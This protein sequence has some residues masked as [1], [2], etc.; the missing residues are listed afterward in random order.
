[1]TQEVI[2]A[3]ILHVRYTQKDFEPQVTDFK[4]QI[5]SF[6]S[7]PVFQLVFVIALFSIIFTPQTAS[8]NIFDFFTHTA[9]AD[10]TT[11]TPSGNTDN[12]QKM[13]IPEPN[14]GPNTSDNIDP[15]VSDI[16]INN[17]ALTP[18]VGPLGSTLDVADIPEGGGQINIYTVHAGDTIGSIAQM[19]NVSKATIIDA[20]DLTRGQ[21]LQQGT[22]LAIPS[23]SGHIHTVKNGDTVK[24]LAKKYKVDA[25]DIAEYND[26]DIDSELTE[27]TTLIIP[28][29]TYTD[30]STPNTLKN[31]SQKSNSSTKKSNQQSNLS[32]N[33]TNLGPITAH[34]M[35]IDIKVDLGNALLRP[36]DI[37]V[38]YESQGAHG[39]FGSAV[40]LAAPT[41]T[42]IHASAD[43]TVVLA[44][45]SGWNSGYGAYV[46]IMS[47]ID[48][49]VVQTIYAHMSKVI[50]TV[51]EQVNRGDTIG[52][53]GR[54]GNA[55]GPHVHFEVHGAL[56]PLTINSDYT[57]E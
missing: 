7:K 56:N 30:T 24:S 21:S 36:V 17:A 16:T 1:M 39:I 48:G 14:V 4:A 2:H 34:P 46:I 41:G 42:P 40:D 54:T 57:G 51:G 22:I 37:G 33:G 12:S 25:I 43:G 44:R 55:T 18:K 9:N 45:A 53:V 10:T 29:I 50:A 49:N 38:S 52:L 6:F 15:S 31:T 28:D 13:A 35:R 19:F 26:L 32:Q 27:G 47:D 3:S 20:N 11:N 8:A 5:Y 23:I